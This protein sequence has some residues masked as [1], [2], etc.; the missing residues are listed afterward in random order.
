MWIRRT[1]PFRCC[2]SKQ[3]VPDREKSP[4]V[5]LRQGIFMGNCPYFTLWQAYKAPV[6]GSVAVG[7]HGQLLGLAWQAGIALQREG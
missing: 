7:Q 3:T 5:L 1:L 2:L 6:T 4:A